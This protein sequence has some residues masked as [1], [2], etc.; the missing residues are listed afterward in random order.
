M[1]ILDFSF[2]GGTEHVTKLQ[3]NSSSWADHRCV[4]HHFSSLTRW[5]GSRGQVW[6]GNDKKRTLNYNFSSLV[7]I[8][9]SNDDDEEKEEEEKDEEE[10]TEKEL[11]E[12]AEVEGEERE[13]KHGAGEEEQ[14]AEG[15]EADDDAAGPW[16]Q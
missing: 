15:I 11:E 6:P 13:E 3:S 16:P 12:R 14:E 2:D 9:L 1:W 5:Q 8:K 7:L 10:D 4:L